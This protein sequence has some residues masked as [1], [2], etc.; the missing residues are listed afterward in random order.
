MKKKII[1]LLSIIITLIILILLKSIIKKNENQKIKQITNEYINAINKKEIQDGDY[2]ITEDGIYNEFTNIKIESKEKQISG[3]IYIYNNKIV[4]GCININN[5]G[6]NIENNEIINTEKEKCHY[7][8]LKNEEETL[9]EY[10]ENY[11]NLVKTIDITES[12]IYDINM[13]NEK[14]PYL[15]ETPT[16][17]WIKL[18]YNEIDGIN[19]LEYSIKYRNKAYSYDG[20]NKEITQEIKQGGINE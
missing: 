17:G 20:K 19:V 7:I 8:E 2:N 3:S 18:E 15:D 12:G 9:K 10:I 4:N 6:V 1:I 13:I 14:L 16:E 11:I 5:Y